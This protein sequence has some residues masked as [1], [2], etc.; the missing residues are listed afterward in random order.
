MFDLN[1]FLGL[2]FK[3]GRY[4]YPERIF[5]EGSP[6]MGTKY[7][8]GQEMPDLRTYV[9]IYMYMRYMYR[10]TNRNRHDALEDSAYAVGGGNRLHQGEAVKEEMPGV[11]VGGRLS[12]AG[13]SGTSVR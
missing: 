3:H 6:A 10:E 8:A 12:A 5:G 11:R 4:M 9:C 13:L 1:K 2:A 7:S